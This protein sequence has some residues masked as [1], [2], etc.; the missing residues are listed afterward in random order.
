[1]TV[2]SSGVR[3]A[4]YSSALCFYRLDDEVT[5]RWLNEP[6][7]SARLSSDDEGRKRLL[8][9]KGITTKLLWDLAPKFDRYLRESG[10][11][12]LHPWQ[13]ETHDY[14][15]T[16]KKPT[17]FAQSNLVRWATTKGWCDSYRP[18]SPVC[19]GFQV[20]PATR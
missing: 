14:V 20:T 2:L 8:M 10:T 17:A 7:P 12:T 1:V 5:L 15:S 19:I 3:H 9:A 13:Q 4:V 11:A 18:S 6:C 16:A